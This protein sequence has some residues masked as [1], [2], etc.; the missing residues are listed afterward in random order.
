MKELTQ[1]EI[2]SVSGAG[3]LADLGTI[4]GNTIDMGTSLAGKST[5]YTVG[6]SQLFTGIEAITRL[7][8]IGAVSNMTMGIVNIVAAAK[9]S[10][11]QG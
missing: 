4:I 5:N 7:N 8:A 3:F 2:Q 11:A 1:S 10:K 6:F 9:H